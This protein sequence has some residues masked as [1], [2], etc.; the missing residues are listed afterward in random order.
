M[1]GSECWNT[2]NGMGNGNSGSRLWPGWICPG[3][4]APAVTAAMEWKRRESEKEARE[5]RDKSGSKC[6]ELFPLDSV[7]SSHQV[8]RHAPSRCDLPR[9]IIRCISFAKEA[10]ERAPSGRVSLHILLNPS[11]HAAW[12]ADHEQKLWA[13]AWPKGGQ[14]VTAS[15]S[16]LLCSAPRCLFPLSV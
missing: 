13:S 5:R 11:P 14:L 3:A 10:S 15:F 8:L 6:W 7:D 12:T 16:S 4:L 2:D 9:S 1:N